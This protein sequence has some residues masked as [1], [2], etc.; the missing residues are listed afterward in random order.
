MTECP[1]CE[2]ELAEDANG[3]Y[4]PRCGWRPLNQLTR[5]DIYKAKQ[6]YL[7]ESMK[8][9]IKMINLRLKEKRHA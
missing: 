4:C 3:R 5:L 2:I 6:K 9:K 8:Y 1:R 7:I